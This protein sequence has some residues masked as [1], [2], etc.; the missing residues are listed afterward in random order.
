MQDNMPTVA[1]CRLIELQQI[2]DRA[3]NITPVTGA[4][5]VPFKI[6]RV[7]F[8]YDIPSGQERGEHVHKSCH[9]LLVA[10]SGSFEVVL[11]DGESQRVVLLNRPNYALQVPPG[12]WSSQ[13]RYS[14]AAVCLVLASEVYDEEDYIRNYELFKEWRCT[15][16]Q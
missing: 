2:Q 7:F 13:R 3:G 9:Q 11:D 16:S 12:V 5:D 6:R 15:T 4:V 14:A 1:D 10:V 8:V